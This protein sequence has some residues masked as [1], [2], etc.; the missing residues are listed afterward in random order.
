MR[1]PRARGFDLLIVLQRRDAASSCAL[2]ACG[3]ARA[4]A[5]PR[6]WPRRTRAAADGSGSAAHRPSD[7]LAG[8]L[9]RADRQ[10]EMARRVERERRPRQ[11]VAL[12]PR[13]AQSANQRAS[14]RKSAERSLRPLR[15]SF[16]RRDGG[17]Q[18]AESPLALSS[19]AARPA[20]VRDR[21]W[22]NQPRRPFQRSR[23]ACVR[24]PAR[25]GAVRDCVAR[26]RVARLAPRRLR[27]RGWNERLELD[28]CVARSCPE[29]V[30]RSPM[31]RSR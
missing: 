25:S 5:A 14:T 12:R 28:E 9:R 31:K 27:S 13:P 1:E 6:R 23:Q 18:I 22:T 20:A 17:E 7:V 24:A 4:P 10:R 15:R 2:R 29:R 16:K 19:A 21:V 30:T 8:S 3:R 11:A 26:R